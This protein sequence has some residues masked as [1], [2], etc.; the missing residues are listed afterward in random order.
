[1]SRVKG[2]YGL[3]VALF[4]V[5][6]NAALV[7]NYYYNS[8]INGPTH[9]MFLASFLISAA[10]T[11][12]RQYYIWLPLNILLV[13]GTM[14]LERIY[15]ESIQLTYKD[16]GGRFTDILFS[17]YG[18]AVFTLMVTVFIKR[19]YNRQ[20][21]VLVAQSAALQ[22][23]N[24]TKNKLLSILGHDLKEPLASLQGYLELIEDFDLSE[25]EKKA[26]NRQILVMTKNTSL[27]LSNILAWTS[28]Q[29]H[30]FRV[31]MQPLKIREVLKPVIEIADGISYRKRILTRCD[32]H[33][34][35]AVIADPQMF[36]LII[37]NLLMN[38]IKFTPGGG[39]VSLGVKNQNGEC[40]ITVEDN[41]IGI[42]ETIQ[43]DIFSLR[44]GS[45]RGT[46]AEKGNGLGLKLCWEFT[47]LMGGRLNFISKSGQGTAFT[48][49][50]PS[51]NKPGEN[52]DA[53][54][55]E[56]PDS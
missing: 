38:A 9:I 40:I 8:G 11:P 16:A 27:M 34:D 49:V 36:E 53:G 13:T 12:S 37:R 1:M 15:P 56:T 55:N 43:A 5:F 25:E 10:T 4:Q 51:A 30:N 2:W 26:M 22:E 44:S 17:Y 18:I 7:I 19:A 28:S 31:D 35:A 41:G 29:E 14:V 45:R 23:A 48:L 33:A 42:P 32:I 39:S 3:S 20:R 52:Y 24:Q 46:D 50:L 6:V 54:T 21:E 47:K